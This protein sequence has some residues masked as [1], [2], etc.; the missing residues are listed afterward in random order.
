MGRDF[1]VFLKDNQNIKKGPANS[2]PFLV[3][4]SWSVG[5]MPSLKKPC[6][7]PEPLDKKWT[8]SCHEPSRKSDR[9][10]YEEMC[11]DEEP[12]PVSW[13]PEHYNQTPQAHG[14]QALSP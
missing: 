7:E 4:I 3:E 11:F 10:A 12:G 6:G 14:W 8:G 13:E 2:W 9:T 5:S 1:A